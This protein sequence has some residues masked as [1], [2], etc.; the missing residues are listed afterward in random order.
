MTRCPHSSAARLLLL[1][2]LL[3][4]ELHQRRLAVL[5][6]HLPVAVDDRAARRLYPLGAH[7]VA[8]GLREVAV[9]VEH[10]QVPQPEEDDAEEHEREAADD[11]DPQRE[12]R[13]DRWATVVDGIDHARES[14][15]RPPVV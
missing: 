10:L 13:R 2:N 11:R 7:A 6:Q 4:V 3:G 12:L 1:G 15:D 9:A 5:D 14:G 8:L